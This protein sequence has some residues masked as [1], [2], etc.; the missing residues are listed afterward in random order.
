MTTVGLVVSHD[1]GAAAGLARE[2]TEWL[3]SEG[4]EVALVA[5]D[6]DATGL[7]DLGREP[8]AFPRGLDLA[9]CLGGDGTMREQ[10]VRPSPG[11]SPAT[12]RSRTG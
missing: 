5:D 11:S 6:A 10:R 3:T 2:L 9:V 7:G 1:P 12:T 4:H 8:E